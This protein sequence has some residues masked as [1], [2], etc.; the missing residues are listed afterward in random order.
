VDFKKNFRYLADILD[1]SDRA[2][3]VLAEYDQRIQRFRKQ[4][5]ENLQ[6][7]TV[8]VVHLIGSTVSIYGPG[9]VPY[10]QVMADAGIQLV[11]AY[12]NLENGYLGLSIENL[13]DWDADILFVVIS[14][15]RDAKNLKSLSFLKQP[16]W[17]KLKAVQNGQ[18]YAVNWAHTVVGPI[19]ATRFIDELYE[20][21]NTS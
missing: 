21:F 17:S 4:L 10:G 8:S 15:T 5:E 3:E 19:T 13:P 14:Q 6:T 2:E 18:V 12:K 1:R 20:Y 11:P 7:N 9:I 16:I